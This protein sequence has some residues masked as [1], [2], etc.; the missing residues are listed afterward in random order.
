[1]HVLDVTKGAA[2]QIIV[3]KVEVS[4]G[5]IKKGDKLHLVVDEAFRRRTRANH[6]ATHLL[7]VRDQDC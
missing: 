3:H 6:T 1:M 4:S 2:G 5:C 7:Q